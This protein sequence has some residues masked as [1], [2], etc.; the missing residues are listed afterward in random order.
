MESH[1]KGLDLTPGYQALNNV[2][3]I[4]DSEQCK[5]NKLCSLADGKTALLLKPV[6]SRA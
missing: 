2:L 6:K 4:K 5:T 1:Y 3:N